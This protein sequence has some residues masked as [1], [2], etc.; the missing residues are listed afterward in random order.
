[1]TPYR[2]ICLTELD[3]VRI[4]SM[5]HDTR[6]RMPDERSSID[7]LEQRLDAARIVHQTSIEPH[8]V[9]MNSVVLLTDCATS[10]ESELTLVYPKDADP[11][12]SR[13]SV[14]SPMGRALIGACVGDHVRIT[15]PGQPDRTFLVTA[16]PYQPEA[17]GR[18]DI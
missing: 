18:Y 3:V 11:H 4:E 12:R 6:F 7:A 8:V 1:M 2:E 16:V 5:L 15:V 14:L 17:S 10:A 13:V 9:T